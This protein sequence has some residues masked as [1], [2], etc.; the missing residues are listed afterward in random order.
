MVLKSINKTFQTETIIMTTCYC[1]SNTIYDKYI[2]V[3]GQYEA[4]LISIFM[5]II[6]MSKIGA[7]PRGKLLPLKRF[8]V[9]YMIVLAF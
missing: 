6:E 2:D 9:R 4:H 1:T 8:L 7:K 5:N 3:K